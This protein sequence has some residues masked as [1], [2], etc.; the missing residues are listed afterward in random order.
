M[1][2]LIFSLQLTVLQLTSKI[3]IE[4]SFFTLGLQIG[5]TL[6]AGQ[7]EEMGLRWQK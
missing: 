5:A 2:M 1:V 4:D 3:S 6:A 7:L